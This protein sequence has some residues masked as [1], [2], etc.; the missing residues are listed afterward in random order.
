AARVFAH[1]EAVELARR[2]LRRLETLPEAAD[3]DALE[4]PL[5]V[6]LGM[7]LQVREGF[8]APEVYAVYARARELCGRVAGGQPPFP[9]LWGLWLFHKV[10]SELVRARE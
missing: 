4:L 3:R 10:R 8:A 2:G 7:Q 6:A 1:E 5:R 9:V